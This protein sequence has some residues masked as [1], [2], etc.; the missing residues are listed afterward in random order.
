LNVIIIILT[1]WHTV[2]EEL[3]NAELSRNPEFVTA[4]ETALLHYCNPSL[5]R[6]SLFTLFL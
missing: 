5:A 4:P 6:V 3:I 1:P 2:L